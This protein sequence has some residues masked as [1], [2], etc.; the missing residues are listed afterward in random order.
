VTQTSPRAHWSL[1][2]AA[3]L[4]ACSTPNHRATHRPSL[5]SNKTEVYDNDIKISEASKAIEVYE[6]L[7]DVPGFTFDEKQG[8]LIAEAG[9]GHEV[10]TRVGLVFPG[11]ENPGMAFWFRKYRPEQRWRKGL[12]YWQVP[13]AW[14]TLGIWKVVPLGY[15][16]D[17]VI[18]HTGGL[19]KIGGRDQRRA[20]LRHGLQIEAER[21]GGDAI[22]LGF[23]SD[24]AAN[25][26]VVKLGSAA[27]STA[28]DE[29]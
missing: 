3:S 26:W 7:E 2:A 18:W 12:C 1:I 9:S 4:F 16:C 8:L 27:P 23:V 13:L 24:Q 28:P 15:P 6:E 11:M 22:M 19:R 29:R 25:G 20:L 17:P 10:L 14:L 21:L 5:S